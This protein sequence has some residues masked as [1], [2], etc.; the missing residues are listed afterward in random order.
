M[1]SCCRLSGHER[2][3]NR[4][5][6]KALAER[7]MQTEQ[8]L[9]DRRLQ[10]AVAPKSPP[11]VDTRT[12]GKTPTFE[13]ERTQLLVMSYQ[14]ISR[15]WQRQREAKATRK[16]KATRRANAKA[17]VS[18]AKATRTRKAKTKTRKARWVLSPL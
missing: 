9:L 2:K 17:K 18:K 6:V 11:L 8:A 16:A 1:K 15:C 5:N 13:G 3:K 12:I 7:L 4:T 14:W 10:V